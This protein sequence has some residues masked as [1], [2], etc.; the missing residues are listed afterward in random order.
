MHVRFYALPHG[1]NF[2]HSISEFIAGMGPFF[3]A[4]AG[5]MFGPAAVSMRSFGK[6]IC[7]SVH[8]YFSGMMSVVMMD[9]VISEVVG[10]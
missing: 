5:A 6:H 3:G 8:D 1:R 10:I 9:L 4:I 2:S 7:R